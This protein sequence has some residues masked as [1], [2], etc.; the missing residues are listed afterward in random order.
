MIPIVVGTN[1]PKALKVV[2]RLAD[3]WVWDGPWE[4]SYRPAYEIL[5]AACEEIGR[6]FDDI[7][8]AAEL[9]ISM[10][11]DSSTFEQAYEV[12]F[13]AGQTFYRSGPT[14]AEVIADIERLVDAGVRHI[15]LNFS[16]LERTPPVCHRGGSPCAPGTCRLRPPAGFG[17]DRLVT[18]RNPRLGAVG[19]MSTQAIRTRTSLSP[20]SI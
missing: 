14:A 5:R 7:T 13:Y 8:L 18:G 12:D 11:S 4:P 17:F 16:E 9:N 15:P 2:A 3:W 6:P 1:G 20:G 19:F 10:P